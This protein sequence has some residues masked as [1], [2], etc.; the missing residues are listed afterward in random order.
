QSGNVIASGN[1]GL[2]DPKAGD[3][4]LKEDSPA[5]GLGF[6]PIPFEEIGLYVDAYRTALPTR[7]SSGNP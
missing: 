7:T 2:T 6:E 4:R 1:P 5:W 3:F